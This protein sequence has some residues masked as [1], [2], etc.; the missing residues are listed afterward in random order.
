MR[1]A[2]AAAAFVGLIGISYAFAEGAG[3][4]SWM[5]YKP[6][7]AGEESNIANPN[8]TRDEMTSWAQAAAAEVLTFDKTGYNER[9][10]ILAKY[11]A[12]DGWT[13]YSEYLKSSKVLDMVM[14]QGYSV[15]AIVADVPEIVNQGA[16]SGVYHWIMRMPITISF[17]KAAAPGAAPQE[18][19][20]GKFYLF[21]DVMRVAE[22]K[23]GSNGLAITKWRIMD[24]P[25]Q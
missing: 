4:P 13:G 20:A 9:M 16:V 24:M 18:G 7:Y 5:E 11:F 25:K 22:G 12:A 23:G 10:K 14:S 19:P 8:H 21:M 1:K 6:S 17:T 15:S 2:L 3:K